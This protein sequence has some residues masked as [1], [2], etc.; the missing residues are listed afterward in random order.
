MN[1]PTYK[2]GK[3]TIFLTATQAMERYQL[4]RETIEKRAQECNAALK[5]GRAKRYNSEKLDAYFKSFEA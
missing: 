5:I 1:K 2:P 3:G 4:G